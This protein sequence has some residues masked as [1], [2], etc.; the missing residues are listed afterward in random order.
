M[1]HVFGGTEISVLGVKCK[2][3]TL[4]TNLLGWVGWAWAIGIIGVVK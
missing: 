2:V 1:V 4:L 3:K